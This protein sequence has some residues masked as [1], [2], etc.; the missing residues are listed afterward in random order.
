MTRRR[1]GTWGSTQWGLSLKLSKCNITRT[2]F[3]QYISND[4]GYVV[5]NLHRPEHQDQITKVLVAGGEPP[6][7]P[8]PP[9]DRIL[10]I[11]VE[12]AVVRTAREHAGYCC[13]S[14]LTIGEIG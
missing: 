2:G 12:A 9:Q 6:N 7:H 4:H 11:G 1:E 14:V 5:S 3:L 13:L 10:G 8:L